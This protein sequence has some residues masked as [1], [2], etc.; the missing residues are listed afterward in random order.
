[1]AFRGHSQYR[2]WN[3]LALGIKEETA[4][5]PDKVDDSLSKDSLRRPRRESWSQ[6]SQRGRGTRGRGVWFIDNRPRTLRRR[7]TMPNS[8]DDYQDQDPIYNNLTNDR[9]DDYNELGVDPIC[10]ESS[11]NFSSS[12]D[13]DDCKNDEEDGIK[14]EDQNCQDES[15]P[16]NNNPYSANNIYHP[17]RSRSTSYLK[18]HWKT[19]SNN[20]DGTQSSS[21]SNGYEP[22]NYNDQWNQNRE[23]EFT[24]NKPDQTWVHDKYEVL[25]SDLDS[26]DKKDASTQVSPLDLNNELPGINNTKKVTVSSCEFSKR[27][28]SDSWKNQTK[29]NKNLELPKEITIKFSDLTLKDSNKEKFESI[30]SK[31]PIQ[32]EL[33][34]MEPE[35]KSEVTS[36]ITSEM[37]SEVTPKEKELAMLI[38]L[39]E[40]DNTGLQ[41]I[42]PRISQD[43]LTLD[44]GSYQNSLLE[45]EVKL[46]ME[47]QSIQT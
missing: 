15:S 24:N 16:W 31:S 37:T 39:D 7:N 11:R 35:V 34:L 5:K 25:E 23:S 46:T 28:E 9:S 4:E 1:M 12:P 38:N 22:D 40:E 2:S 30:I 27:S 13:L 47:R 6:P 3:A 14:Y 44:W 26:K 8:R 17:P 20:N 41:P 18:D 19:N 43:V 10:E 33:L 32:E 36:I 42:Q 45:E 29:S 21:Y